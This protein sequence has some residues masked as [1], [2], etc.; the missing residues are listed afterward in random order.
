M[1]TGCAM[2]SKKETTYLRN[3]LEGTK[4]KYELLREWIFTTQIGHPLSNF[5]LRGGYRRV[6]IYGAGEI[7]LMLCQE[8]QM[9]EDIRI[10]CFIDRVKQDNPFGV[11]TIQR[12]RAGLGED[13]IVVTPTVYFEEIRAQ[14]ERDGAGRIV[15]LKDVILEA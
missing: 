9:T 4:Q 15:S 11:E 3:Q 7:G 14:L 1:N 6:V 10:V 12:Y 13:I 5:F 8:L 2:D